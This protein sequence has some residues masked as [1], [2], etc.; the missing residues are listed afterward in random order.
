MNTSPQHQGR[1]SNYTIINSPIFSPFKNFNFR[2]LKWF[3]IKIIRKRMLRFKIDAE[4]CNTGQIIVTNEVNN[5]FA[6][7]KSASRASSEVNAI[8]KVIRLCIGS[9][10][11][12]VSNINQWISKHKQSRNPLWLH[13][14]AQKQNS[15]THYAL[16]FPCTHHF[17]HLCYYLLVKENHENIQGTSTRR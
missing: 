15:H 17:P 2:R 8:G 13:F 10:E 4:S 1:N 9:Q 11:V 16:K 6:I 3:N 12:V 14:H 7:R 5:G